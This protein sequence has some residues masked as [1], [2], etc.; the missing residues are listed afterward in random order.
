MTH[1][2]TSYI[3]AL[4]KGQRGA[5]NLTFSEAEQAMS[6]IMSGQ[7]EAEQLGAF[8]MLMRVKEETPDELAGFVQAARN[9]VAMPADFPEIALDWAAYAGKRRQLPWFVLSALLLAQRGIKVLMHGT[10]VPGRVCAD[11]ALASLGI[12]SCTSVAQAAQQLQQRDFAYLS[13]PI[14]S[15]RLQHL[16]DLKAILGLRSPLHSAVRMLNPA[17]AGTSMIGIFHPG[18]DEVHQAAAVL[19]ADKNLAVFKGEGGD[20]ERNPDSACTVRMVSQGVAHDEVWPAQFSHRHLKDEDMNIARLG[21]LWRG[22]SADEYALSAVVGTAAIALRALGH[23]PDIE[24]AMQMAAELWQQRDPK[25]LSEPPLSIQPKIGSVALVGAGPGDPDLL[26]LRALRLIQTAEVLVYDNLVA[27]AIVN[28]SN[29]EKIFV[30]KQRDKHTL[31]QEAINDLLV[32]LAVEG[33]RVVRLKGGDP[34]IFGRGGEEIA[35]LAAHGISFQV[36]PGITAA[37]GV[38]AYAGIPLTH[39][40]H[41][42]SCVFVTGHL[43]DGSMDLDWDALARPQQTVVVYMGLLGIETLCAQLIAHGLADTTPAALVQQGTT[44]NQRVLTGTLATLPGIV[45]LEKP[46]AP[47]LIIVGGVVSLREKL[48]WFL[49]A[50]TTS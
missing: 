33:K 35:T 6:L 29:A 17:R 48:N 3:Q 37:S 4:G 9:S 7:V 19:L 5:R 28:M 44:Q 12:V 15:P 26:T 30:G 45:Q 40:D 22:E 2:F 14:L 13:L 46:Q 27:P 1:P 18:Y 20:A 43:K 42:Q 25:F 47:T 31:P 8:L 50:S 24:Q 21:Q 32:R 38:S 49:P 10:H 16:I 23:A 11:D 34:F 39:R 41:A 36:V